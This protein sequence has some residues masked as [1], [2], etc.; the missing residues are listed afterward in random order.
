MKKQI[1]KWTLRIVI[2]GLFIIGLLLLIILKP[3]L[4]YAYK[5]THINY[6]IFHNKPFDQSLITHLDQATELVKKSEFYNPNLKLEICLNDGSKYPVL[7]QKILGQSFAAGFYNKVVLHGMPNYKDNYV[8]LNGYKWN[9]TQLLAHEVTHCLQFDNL[10]FWK[11]SPLGK[12]PTW[13]KEGYPEYIARQNSDQTDLLKNIER[14]IEKQK[15]DKDNW[16]ISFA[17]STFVGKD[18][19]GWWL[20]MQYCMDIKKM[21]YKQ[22]LKDTTTE[23]EIK[24][25]MMNWYYKNH[26]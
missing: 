21:T 23:T 10:G 14:L 12:I 4:T 9:L 1:K 6:I 7:M 2:T 8:E 16:G 15:T 19:Y 11:S 3:S 18:Y 5:T 20:L 22:V 26:D 13:K 17:D 25:E 24:K